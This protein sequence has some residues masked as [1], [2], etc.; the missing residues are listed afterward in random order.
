MAGDGVKKLEIGQKLWCVPSG[1]RGEPHEVTITKVGRL[2]AKIN[3]RRYTRI[4]VNT[5]YMDRGVS[6]SPGR[7]YLT[8]EEWETEV[9]EDKIWSAFHSRMLGKYSKPRGLTADRIREA[10]KL[11]GFEI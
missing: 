4:D 2:W 1:R 10:A 11:L 9:E 5:L 7:C 8:R 3:D 6:S